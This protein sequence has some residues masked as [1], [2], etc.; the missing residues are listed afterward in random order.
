VE[1]APSNEEEDEAEK[2]GGTSVREER[3]ATCFVVCDGF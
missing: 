2:K 1:E 3:K